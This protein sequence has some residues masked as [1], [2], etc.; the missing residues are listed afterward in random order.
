MIKGP[1]LVQS[2]IHKSHS[3]SDIQIYLKIWLQKTRI[4]LCEFSAGAVWRAYWISHILH[5]I[6]EAAF[7]MTCVLGLAHPT[8]DWG[9]CVTCV[10]DLTHPKWE[11]RTEGKCLLDY[12][13]DSES[14][15]FGLLYKVKPHER[16]DSSEV[17]RPRKLCEYLTLKWAHKSQWPSYNQRNS[18]AAEGNRV[19]A[20]PSSEYRLHDQRAVTSAKPAETINVSRCGEW[21]A[22]KESTMSA[23][24]H[25]L[26]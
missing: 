13:S 18:C 3:V 1:I 16:I 12:F 4:S 10:L 9:R 24:M 25:R 26:V 6:E 8:W 23:A 19:K 20:T 7:C 17:R 14:G 21:E 11:F 15:E 5:G 2:K 22:A